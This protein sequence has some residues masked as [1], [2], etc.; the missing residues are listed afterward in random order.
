MFEL[1]DT[2]RI[3]DI[4]LS[5]IVLASQ[6]IY[7]YA[8]KTPTIYSERLSHT[9]ADGA[10]VHLK[11]EN[12]QQI[13]AFKVRGAAH[14]IQ[15]LS[16]EERNKGVTTFSTGNHGLAVAYVAKQMGIRAVICISNDVPNSKVAAIARTGAEIERV[17]HSQDEAE[18]LCRQLNEEQGLTIIQPFDHPHVIAGQGTIGLELLEDVPHLDTVVVPL[19]G[20]GLIAGIALVM[21]SCGRNIRV[22]GV[23][24]ES[25]AAMYESIRRGK[26]TLVN[27]TATLADS[28]RGGIGL[29]NRYTFPIVQS[30]V[31]EIVLVPEV[32]IQ[33]GMQ[34]M[35]KEHGMVVEGAAATGV[36]AILNRQIRNFGKHAVVIISGKNVDEGVLQHLVQG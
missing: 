9:L 19:S 8:K 32:E 11:L 3:S 26:P 17:G 16:D 23:S 7:S 13:G 2:D 35:L 29:D 20:G 33:R 28:L 27:E 12:L 21:K 25:G 24:M 14:A 5:D 30:L 22:V 31:D 36:G 1:A 4:Q 18:A 34:F 15:S 6:Q 10:T